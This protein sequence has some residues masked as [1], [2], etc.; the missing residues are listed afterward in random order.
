MSIEVIATED[1]F[2]G[3]SIKRE[4]AKFTI[5]SE[6]EFSSRWMDKVVK[7][8]RKPNQ[9]ETRESFGTGSGLPLE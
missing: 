2:Y 9:P 1:G 7:R 3:T 6:K 5:N 8:G 4:G